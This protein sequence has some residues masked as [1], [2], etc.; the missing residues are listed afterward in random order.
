MEEFTAWPDL[1]LWNGSALPVWTALI[2]LLLVIFLLMFIRLIRYKKQIRQKEPVTVRPK[3]DRTAPLSVANLQGIGARSEQ[4]DAFGISDLGAY[5]PEGL[6]AVLCDGMG[7]LS[8]GR[9]IA[10]SIVTDLLLNFP[11]GQNETKVLKLL[12][13]ISRGVYAKYRGQGGSTAVV[14]YIREGKLWFWS[15]GDSDLILLR[16]GRLVFL[17]RRHEYHNELMLSVLRGKIDAKAVTEHPNR[18]ALTEFMGNSAVSPDH[19]R[20]PFTLKT[21]DRLLL[22]SDGVT[23]TLTEDEIQKAME[24]PPE[25][26][27]DALE[28]LILQKKL[29]NQDNY[30]AIYIQYKV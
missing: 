27:C 8:C 11:F 12:S 16:N 6:L 10:Q 21:G 9:E 15:I 20:R 5:D 26:C 19:T 22:C 3:Q 1:P 13:D 4:Q 30:T 23:D 29:L 17:N 2:P 14:T 18:S 25:A 7:G 28:R 24:N